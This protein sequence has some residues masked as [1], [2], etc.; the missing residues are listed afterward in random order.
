MKFDL[1][2]NRNLT[3]EKLKI[4]KW[5]SILKIKN[6]NNSKLDLENKKCE[7]KLK[8]EIEN[9]YWKLELIENLSWKSNLGVKRGSKLDNISNIEHLS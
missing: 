5:N 1:E 6:E 2:K 3:L 4:W 9:R 8:I 7:L